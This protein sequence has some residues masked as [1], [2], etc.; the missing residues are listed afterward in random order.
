M[1]VKYSVEE[2]GQKMNALGLWNLLE[3]Y[4]WSVKP[5][6]TVFP[7][8][9]TVIKGDQK[10]VKVRFL[11][12]EGWQTLHDFVRTRVD[13]NFGWYTSPMEMPHFELVV[14]ETGQVKLFR[15][16]TGFMPVEANVSQRELVA[17]ILWEAY[18][19]ML[20]VETDKML[21][22][23]FSSEK[24]IFARIEGSDGTWRDEPLEIPD[25]HPHVERF[26]LNRDDINKAKDLPIVQG[27]VLELEFRILLGLMTKESRPRYV[28][29]L[30]GIDSVTEE[31][32]IDCRVSVHPDQ[33]LKGLWESLPQQV[34]TEFIR[35][36]KVPGEIKVMSGRLF[37]ALRTLCIELP[38]KISLHDSL[39]KIEAAYA[40]N[41]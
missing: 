24:A 22:M 4:N 20:R 38:F 41:G 1:P 9:C 6:G 37:R 18:G 7:Y 26:A 31:R 36:G 35:R 11:M 5:K 39:P 30:V 27:D 28:Y 34:L 10:P 14:L 15:H 23:K 16:D 17:K 3:P 13:R 2:I 29:A 33:G 40:T 25:P 8:F 32:V 21:P 19:V 12:L